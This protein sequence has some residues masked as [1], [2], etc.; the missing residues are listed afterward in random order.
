M[1]RETHRKY[2]DKL[3][4]DVDARVSALEKRMMAM[5]ALLDSA[6]HNQTVIMGSYETHSGYSLH[7]TACIWERMKAEQ[8]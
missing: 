8:K 5:A 7:C 3:R 1:K 6:R 2:Q 4:D